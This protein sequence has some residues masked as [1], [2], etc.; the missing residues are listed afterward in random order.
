LV[1]D[2]RIPAVVIGLKHGIVERR[3]KSTGA[4]TKTLR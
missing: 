1:A 3:E 4:D 2:L